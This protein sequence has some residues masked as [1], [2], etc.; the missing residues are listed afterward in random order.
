[1]P[2]EILP[3]AEGDLGRT[4]FA[5]LLV[6]ALDKQLTGALFLREASGIEHAIRLEAGA[7]VKVRPGDGHA[8]L[9]EMLVEAG[10]IDETTLRGALS[11]HGLLGDALLLAGCVERDLLE[12]TA[13]RQFMMRMTRLFSLGADTTYSYFDGRTDLLDDAAP[14]ATMHPLAVLW[15]GVRAHATASSMMTETIERLRDVTI[16]I[17]PTAAIERFAPTT[18]EREI[19]DRIRTSELA[20]AQLFTAGFAPEETLCWMVYALV[21]TRSLDL[22]LGT[23]PLCAE[24][25]PEPQPAAARPVTLARIRLRAASHRMGA[26]APDLAGDGERSRVQPRPRKRGR[27]SAF[28]LAARRVGTPP[29][30]EAVSERPSG[31]AVT[32]PPPSA[33]VETDPSPPNVPK[34]VAAEPP[35]DAWGRRSDE[36]SSAPKP[37]ASDTESDK[38]PTVPMPPEGQPDAARPAHALYCLA[39]SRIAERD[40]AGALAACQ[41]AREVDPT[42]PDYAALAVW[43]R[44]LVGGADLRARVAELDA[45]LEAREDHTQALFYRGYLRRRI[46]DEPGA[47]QDLRRVLDLDPDHQDAARELHRIAMGKPAKRPSG[48]FRM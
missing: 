13:A 19:L 14:T 39:T 27:P 10:A 7:P 18:E 37:P 25:P 48:Y 6:Y 21:I 12:Q 34:P 24:I 22:G 47:V 15:A 1:M 11:M 38:A 36:P 30:M 16:R 32:E 29:P 35:S 3:T 41:L 28:T 17:H 5:H 9:G 44:S 8:M 42:Q 43:I 40:L 46:G 26:A 2:A 23:T 33:V 20:L 31:A 45:L 4:P